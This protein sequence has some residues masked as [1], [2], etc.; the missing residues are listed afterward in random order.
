[1]HLKAIA[2]LKTLYLTGNNLTNAG[3]EHLK[4]LRA[5]TFLD[6]RHNKFT[7]DDVKLVFDTPIPQLLSLVRLMNSQGGRGTTRPH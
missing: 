5:L 2:K 7:P 3:L 4:S 1:V 6:I